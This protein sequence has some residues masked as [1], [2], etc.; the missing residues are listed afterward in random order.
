MRY[1]KNT[2]VKYWK[3]E[4]KYKQSV[5]AVFDS[6]VEAS[7]AKE[8][9]NAAKET[10]TARESGVWKDGYIGTYSSA[11]SKGVYHFTFNSE[12]GEMTKPELFC[13]AANA[14]W[15]SL[16]GD[17]IAFP[18]EKDGRAGTRFVRITG[19]DVK[20][21][22]EVL[23][24][25]DTPCFILQ[26]GEW[27][28]TANY[29]DGTVM[30]YHTRAD[31]VSAVKRIENGAEAGCHQILLHGK[32]LMVPCLTW[33][34][35]RLFD[36]TDGFRS[37]GAIRFPEGSGPR[38]GVFNKAHTRL[39]VVSEW[40]NELFVF[41]VREDQFILRR[42]IS[43]LPQES[44][45]GG[46]GQEAAS[47]AVRLTKDE[48]FLYVSVRG[49]DMIAV[50]DVSEDV[51]KVVEHVSC[52]GE[53]PRDFILTEDERYLVVAN[54]FAGGIVCMERDERS[55]RI[56]GIRSRIPMPQGVSLTIKES[57]DQGG[58]KE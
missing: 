6:Y 27:I 45:I 5:P 53:H 28:Y 34:V 9:N 58:N 24:E 35:I 3:K 10:E 54:R 56:T 47:A 42:H 30:V 26:D 14:K 49:L 38:H 12:N 57:T 55:G 25:K 44:R 52:G 1:K 50:F 41:R 15:V 20:P 11:E 7:M 22:G 43:I 37:A 40:S 2:L 17:M 8:K 21:V 32:Y 16:S 23:G 18:T 51:V 19:R 13:E 4:H 48:R 33:H 36:R 39:Y 31:G 29:H 46:E